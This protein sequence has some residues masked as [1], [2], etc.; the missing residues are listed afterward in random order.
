VSGHAHHHHHAVRP[1]T[2][3]VLAVGGEAAG[4][5]DPGRPAAE[6]GRALAD[7]VVAALG[8]HPGGPDE[9]VVVVIPMTFG[10]QPSLVADAARTL[11]DVRTRF[12]AGSVCLAAPFG[13]ASHHV[14]H[15]RAAMRRGSGA[16]AGTDPGSA[17]VVGRSIDPFADAEL[18]RRARLA[19]QYGAARL[20]EVAFDGG[21]DP[22]PD[23]AAGL[24]R[25][26]RLG[27]VGPLLV[28]AGFGPAPSGDTL[29]GAAAVRAV[30][31]GRA[32]DA[33]H[34]LAHGDDGV[35][36]GV[37]AEDGHGYAHSHV[38]ADGT[39]YTHSH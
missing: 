18:F 5:P 21:T 28:P 15:L 20:V 39:V 30:I 7:A 29:L 2:A 9:L 33:R 25:C 11:R 37:D 38:A 10:L 35:D 26:R 13:D 23:L 17:L 6:P 24:D 22:D 12:G 14:A 36:A 19:R 1:E 4:M 27:G 31:D 34:A 8:T 32:A 16:G 3:V